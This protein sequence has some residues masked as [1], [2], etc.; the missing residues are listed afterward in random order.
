MDGSRFDELAR[1]LGRLR[2]RRG[3][4]GASLGAVAAGLLLGAGRADAGCRRVSARCQGAN[5]C[6][7]GAR[8]RRRRCRCRPALTTCADGRCHD[9][10]SDP[11]HCGACDVA[12]D[13]ERQCV[14]NDCI[15]CPGD[16]PACNHVCCDAGGACLPRS[17]DEGP[18][19]CPPD[20]IFVECPDDRVGV[21]NDG[22]PVCEP[23]D[24]LPAK[25]CTRADLCGARCCLEK[26]P[27]GKVCAALSPAWLRSR[28]GN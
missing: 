4:L 8:C 12:C 15:P 1:A 21:D 20:R 9:L 17:D 19:C 6:C 25:C 7:D 5:E 24:P 11:A 2:S 10:T 13:P 22:Y 28:G 23:G 27:C 18:T 14:V 3:A 26:I 16:V